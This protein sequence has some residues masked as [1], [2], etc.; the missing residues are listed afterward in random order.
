MMTIVE[1][2][3]EW[4]MR[5]GRILEDK[6]EEWQNKEQERLNHIVKKK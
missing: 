4:R 6:R 3:E 1:G 2:N 5:Y